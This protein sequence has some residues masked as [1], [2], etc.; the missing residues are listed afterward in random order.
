MKEIGRFHKCFSSVVGPNGSGKSNVIDAMLFVFGK[1]AKKLRLNKVSELIHKSDAVKNNP[2]TFARVS[3]FFQ[4]IIDRGDGDDDYEVVPNSEVVVTRIARKDNSSSYKLD[5]KNCSFRDVANYLDSKG[6][7]LDNNRFL[8]LQGEVEMISMMPPKGKTEDDDG[9]LEYLE[10]IIGSSKF[11]E[12]TN[13]AAQKVDQLTEQRQ[14]KLNRVKAVEKE[15]N[16]LEGAKQEA[17]ALLGKDREIRRKRNILYQI[18]TMKEFKTIASATEKKQV[19]EEKLEAERK[20]E[21]HNAERVRELENALK[22][23]TKEYDKIHDELKTTKDE[24]TSFERRDI[25]LREEIKYART[26][27]KK[28]ETKVTT[29]AKKEKDAIRKGQEAEESIPELEQQIVELTKR[30]EEEDAKLEQIHEEMQGATQ[31]LRVQLEQKTQE[32]APVNQERAVFQANL[33][34]A[35]TEVKLLEDSTKRARERLGAAE[36][37]LATLD[38]KQQAKRDELAAGKEEL[39][40]TK[41]RIVKAEKEEKALADKEGSLLQRSRDLLVS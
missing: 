22:E 12:D 28:I 38:E 13:L 20:K 5:G 31:K 29:E 36:E 9:L 16:N 10:D 41:D 14:E 30:R 7:D 40:K 19:V 1:R 18:N 6:I 23:Q 25:K 34:T 3:V 39:A 27:K 26:Q 33:E 32:L 2:P 37:E 24:F 8:I 21:S 35:E 11:V 4:E 17:E 15:K